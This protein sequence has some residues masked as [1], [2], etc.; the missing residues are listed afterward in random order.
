MFDAALPKVGFIPAAA[1]VK[2]YRGRT[3]TKT[4]HD[5][6][7]VF[8]RDG[9]HY[10]AEIKNTLR[11]IDREEL[12]VKLEMCRELELVPLFIM[13]MAP[14][15]YIDMINRQGGYALIF[16]WQLYPHG[17]SDL[18]RLVRDKLGL[19]VDS[20]AAIEVGTLQRFLK[21]HI[22]KHGIEP[23]GNM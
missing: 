3:W 2:Q 9:I 13:R 10:G 11:Y 4:G 6:D 14:K 7:R 12:E 20:P 1:N 17:Y 22:W 8:E 23:R 15:S 5:L 21:W 19:P 16:E 18:G